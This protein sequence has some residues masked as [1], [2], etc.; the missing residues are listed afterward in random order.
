MIAIGKNQSPKAS[1]IA[2]GSLLGIE[3]MS[4]AEI[5]S[6]LKGAARMN[7]RRSRPMLRGKRVLLLFYE[8]STRTRSSFEIAAKSLGAMTTLV[9]SSGSSIEK[10][11]SLLDTVYTLRAVGADILVIR[12]PNAGAPLL[13]AR[14]LDI[15]VINAG[16]GMHEH[17]SQ[18]LLD[19]YTILRHKKTLNGLHITIVGDIYHSRVARSAIHLYSKFGAKI[20]LCGPADFLPELAASLAPGLHLSRTVEDAVRGADAVM[21]LRVQKERL[22]GKK[23]SLQEYILKYQITTER[24]K[25]AKKDA[26]LMHPGPIVRGL[27]LTSEVADC[28][29]SVIVEEVQNGVPVRMAILARALGKGKGRR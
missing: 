17:P 21:V 15:P 29:Q 2:S 6:L 8:P 9:Q 28:P 20:T 23:I 22:A 10:G 5:M 18:A 19:A 1:G 13:A 4:A 24:L 7:P 14:H 11:E 26:L 12:H 16:D 3:H 27:E 25:L